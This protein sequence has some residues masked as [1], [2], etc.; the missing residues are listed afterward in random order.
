MYLVILIIVITILLW[1]K[2]SRS[3]PP[4]PPRL[5]LIGSI[6]F[7]TLKNGVLDWTM[8][9]AVTKHKLATVCLGPRK[10]FMINDYELAKDLFAREEFS[11]RRVSEFHL[12]HRFFSRKPQG[13]INTQGHQWETQ[14][15]FS[16]K[17]LKDFG[18]GKQSIEAAINVEIDDIVEQFLATK[19]D[20]LLGQ[21]F[22]LPIINILW[23]LV[24]GKRF[25]KDD[26]EDMKLVENVTEVFKV[27]VK[28]ALFPLFISKTFPKMTG[29]AKRVEVTEGQ[30]EYFKKVIEEHQDSLD[31]NNLRD[32]IDVYLVEIAKKSKSSDFNVEDLG[33]IMTDI[34]LAG[35][36]TSSTT[37]KWIVLYL[38]IHQDI[39]QRS[40]VM[41][42]LSR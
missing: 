5:P 41:N 32:F 42:N 29:Y 2:V 37:L 40:A 36:E 34:F 14:R 24:A 13:I 3:L 28:T 39:Q 22:N 17:T 1:K 7:L 27:G 18:F 33:M 15:R 21:D 31:E 6:P 26:Q 35:T 10:L 19:G 38:T 20:V 11:G 30:K 4:G 16:L 8:D 12:A 25:E 23:Q 9:Q